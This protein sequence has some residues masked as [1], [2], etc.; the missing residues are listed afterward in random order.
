MSTINGNTQHQKTQKADERRQ[1]IV[2]FGIVIAFFLCHI[3]RIIVNIEEI[4]TYD[5]WVKTEERANKTGQYCG[6]VQFWTMIT[7]DY[8]FLLLQINASINFF[9][10]C[11]FSKQFQIPIAGCGTIQLNINGYYLHI[12][13][14]LKSIQITSLFHEQG[15]I[16]QLLSLALM[17]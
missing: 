3:L 11:F 14:N 1:A 9:I 4:I 12:H 6:G 17:K 5:D 13:D 10:Y 8:S 15:G 7:T 2:L 16:N